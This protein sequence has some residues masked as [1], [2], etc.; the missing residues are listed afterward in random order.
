MIT[1]SQYM[2]DVLFKMGLRENVEAHLLLNVITNISFA[3][4]HKI[5]RRC[6]KDAII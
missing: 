4:L 5:T 1:F 6:K 2:E 3:V